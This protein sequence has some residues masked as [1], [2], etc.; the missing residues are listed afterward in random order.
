MDLWEIIWY[1]PPSCRI[2]SPRWW[3]C[4]GAAGTGPSWDEKSATVVPLQ[5]FYN[6]F[7]IGKL[8]LKMGKNF[9]SLLLSP[10]DMALM[11]AAVSV[12]LGCRG[13]EEGEEG[14]RNWVGEKH[15]E[16]IY[17]VC[18]YWQVQVKDHNISHKLL[19]CKCL[20]QIDMHTVY[21]YNTGIDENI[22]YES[23]NQA[24]YNSYR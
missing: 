3:R 2:Q 16:Y 18:L 11:A 1:S 17:T 22:Y 12:S 20:L 4:R 24:Y 15:C 8:Y 19:G 21:R 10:T 13:E 6:C 5:M 9:P 14:W 7:K 23:N